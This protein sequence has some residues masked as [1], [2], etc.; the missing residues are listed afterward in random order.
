M[1]QPTNEGRR[2][3]PPRREP[4]TLSVRQPHP[5]GEVTP[6]RA[7][8]ALWQRKVPAPQGRAARGGV[9]V[10]NPSPRGRIMYVRPGAPPPPSTAARPGRLSPLRRRRRARHRLGPRVCT[11]RRPPAAAA[12]RRLRPGR[13]RPRS[14]TGTH[15]MRART[16]SRKRMGARRVGWWAGT[17]ESLVEK[18]MI[19]R[20]GHILT[21]TQK[22]LETTQSINLYVRR[23]TST[24]RWRERPKGRHALHRARRQRPRRLPRLPRKGW[25]ARA[26]ARSCVDCSTAAAVCMG[27]EASGRHAVDGDGGAP[28]AHDAAQAAPRGRPARATIAPRRQW[29]FISK[30][31]H[32]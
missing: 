22:Q 7:V 10:Q 6:K 24:A 8:G 31:L 12:A 4:Q 13:W 27:S 16:S 25:R 29:A 1:N 19:K 14:G 23:R 26:L 32:P 5:G 9:P 18:G 21:A 2:A 11:Y 15:A 30:L 28:G 20:R 17:Q 3:G